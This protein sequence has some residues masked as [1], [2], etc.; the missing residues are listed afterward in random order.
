MVKFVA[1]SLALLFGVS[2][3]ERTVV[4]REE[5]PA[6]PPGLSVASQKAVDNGKKHLRKG[7]CG[8]AIREFNKA[9]EKD[10][11]NFEAIYWLGVAQGMCGYYSQAYDRL[12]IAIKYSPNDL[13]KAR[14]YAT[15]GLILIYMGKDDDAVIYLE[16]ARIIDPRNEIVISYYEYEDKKG[17]KGKIK[18]KPKG[19]EGFQIVLRWL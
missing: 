11:T 14:V 1:F 6:R 13:W 16:R 5:A 12:S 17:K 7:N 10:P 4:I 9:L 18:K 19:E 3:V 15:I 2:C 8:K